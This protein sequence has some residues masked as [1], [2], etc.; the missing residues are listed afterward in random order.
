MPLTAD[1]LVR[2]GVPRD[3]AERYLPLLTAGMREFDI[4]TQRR[5]RF[6]LAQ[7]LEESGAF[8]WF[9][10]LAS[11]AEYE[12]RRDL[13]NVRPGD[14]VRYKGRGP[15]QLTGRSNYRFYGH[16]LGIDLE[17]H[18]EL[19][20]RP[21]VGFRTAA[22]YFQ[23]TG[24]NQLADRGDF[25]G[26]TR[27]ING[28]TRGLAERKRYLSLLRRSDCTPGRLGIAR[29]DSGDAVNV[30]TRRL[31]Y[32]HSPKTDK[33]YLDGKRQKFDHEAEAALVKFQKEHD[34]KPTGVF[35]A[36][37]QNALARRVA[38]RKK[39][40]AVLKKQ[41]QAQAQTQ[42]V[43]APVRRSTAELLAELDRVD[44][45]RARLLK[46]LIE[47]G[48]ALEARGAPPPPV[49]NGGH[50]DLHE[51]A[52]EVARIDAMVHALRARIDAAEHPVAV[53][54]PS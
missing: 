43:A 22:M 8:K 49:T 9:E 25:V 40:V 27:R 42:K 34:L 15:I 21:R 32:V 35:D 52:Q 41:K 36:P 24:C 50:I 16:K 13:G 11:G 37:T 3:K 45:V 39:H 26:V 10:E 5:S 12:S 44:A 2:F 4:T 51:L 28:G 18:P 47:R 33:P 7:L 38:A 17:A 46:R 23:T 54:G 30:M 14:G 1:T 19:A 29:G 48:A 6:Y 53:G 20:S 31:S